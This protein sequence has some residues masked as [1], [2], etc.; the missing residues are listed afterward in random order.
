MGGVSR[1]QSLGDVIRCV[2]CRLLWWRDG[3]GATA[4][5]GLVASCCLRACDCAVLAG[6]VD[7]A[8]GD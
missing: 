2:D 1:W 8:G 3:R 7:D 5:Y 6:V 4:R